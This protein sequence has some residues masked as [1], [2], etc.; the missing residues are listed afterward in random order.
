M[1]KAGAWPAAALFWLGLVFC[2][3]PWAWFAAHMAANSDILWLCEALRRIFAGGTPA[4]NAFEVNPP[5]SLLTCLPPFLLSRLGVPLPNA[6]T[7]YA[8]SAVAVSAACVVSILRRWD[9]LSSRQVAVMVAGFVVGETIL[10]SNT[11]IGERDHL[12]ALTCVPFT[13]I[14]LAISYGLPWSRRTGWTVLLLGGFLFLIKPHYGLLPVLLLLH[15]AILQRRLSLWRDADFIALAAASAISAAATWLFFPDWVTV[16][17][18]DAVKLYTSVRDPDLPRE[19]LQLALAAGCL[20][21]VSMVTIKS[22]E[23]RRIVFFLMLSAFICLVPVYAQGRGYHYHLFPFFGFIGL[24]LGLTVNELIAARL[25]QNRRALFHA[26]WCWPAPPMRSR[27]PTS[28]IRPAGN[29][30][31]S[32]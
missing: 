8:V 24:T 4:N 2:L 5:L 3:T 30:R 28:I 22:R 20:L 6:I 17:F 1:T 15:R 16:I 21:A 13:L 26:K 12:I 29:I 7:L 32:R 31:I 11:Y 10:G 18:P 9:F 23:P 14:Q 25:R 19:I 27:R